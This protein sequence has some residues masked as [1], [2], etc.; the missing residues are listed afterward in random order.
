MSGYTG[1][2]IPAGFVQNT[3]TDQM[4]SAFAGDLY[5]MS[6]YNLCDHVSVQ[7]AN[8]IGTGLGVKRTF[9]TTT[10]TRQGANSENAL[11][12]LAGSADADFYGI[13][14]R[15][16]AGFSD[17]TGSGYWP[18]DR[19]APVLRRGRSGGRV[20]VKAYGAVTAGTVALWRV[21]ADITANAAPV[22]A[23]VPAAITQDAVT[24]TVQLTNVTFV[25]SAADGGMA[26]VEL[27]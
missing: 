24:D 13:M 18:K 20:W 11:L 2:P 22:G 23:L 19:T 6:D 26:L 16:H 1:I 4:G 7:E 27:A 8:G 25:T 17:S 9:N 5:S 15:T 12:P 10:A 3:Y 14:I 21:K